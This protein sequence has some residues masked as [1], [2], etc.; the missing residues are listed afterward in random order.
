MRINKRQLFFPLR[1]KFLF[2]FTLFIVIPVLYMM[3]LYFDQSD[4]IFSSTMTDTQNQVLNR[5]ADR[6]DDMLNRTLNVSNLLTNDYDV[7]QLLRKTG[8][9]DLD[10]YPTFQRVIGLQSKMDNLLAYILDNHAIV[11]VYGFNGSI[12]ATNQDKAIVNIIPDYIQQAREKNGAPVWGVNSSLKVKGMEGNDVGGFITM[13][14]LI[15]GETT[16]GYGLVFIA[17]PIKEMFLVAS[18]LDENSPD[19]F[20]I[21][22]ESRLLWGRGGFVEQA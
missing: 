16:K 5:V 10:D 4:K 22:D 20:L 8:Q 18:G 21:S 6:A 15:K 11:A 1:L 12:Y 14:R 7:L 13:V 3:Y 19:Q 17:F 9:L 2:A